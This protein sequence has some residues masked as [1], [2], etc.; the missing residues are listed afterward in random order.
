MVQKGKERNPRNWGS[1]PGTPE[2]RASIA[3]SRLEDITRLVSEIIWETDE[4]ELLTYVSPRAVQIIEMLPEQM[5]GKKLSDLGTFLSAD[6]E[7]MEPNWSK[8]FR[9]HLFKIK[10]GKGKERALLVSGLP[11]F[12]KETWQLRGVYGTAVD[13]TENL[14]T[15]KERDFQKFAMD[16]HAIVSIVDVEGNITYAND[17]FC[18][19]SGY[20][21]D[22]LI[23][24]NHRLVNSG[25]HPPAF[26]ADLW[27]T[28]TNGQVWRGHIRNLKKD[29]SYYWVDATI[30]PSLN[31]KGKPFQYIAIRTDITRLKET[32]RTLEKSESRYRQ[33]AEVSSDWVWEMDENLRFTHLSEGYQRLTGIDPSYSLGK[34]RD[35]LT[36]E[37][38][39]AKPQWQEHL[40]D[41]KEMREFRNF[42]YVYVDPAGEKRHF[43]ISGSPVHDE[44]DNFLGYRGTSSD[45]SDREEAKL[46][47]ELAKDEADKAN[48]AKSEFLSSM[49]HELRTPMNAILGFG[50]MLDFN[51]QEPLTK[52]QKSNVE[53]ILKGGKHLLDLINDVLDLTKIEAGK[54]ELSIEDIPIDAV[55]NDS[56]T[57]VRD[58][59][60]S[61]DIKISVPDADMVI[62]SVRADFTRLKQVVLNL[63]SNA[64]KY[65]R[66]G[67]AVTV[68]YKKTPEGQVRVSITDTGEGI[69]E[70]MQSELF[71]AFSRL[72]AERSEI[73]G[74]GIGLVVCQDLIELMDGKIGF[75]SEEGKGSTF[76]F[77]LSVAT[78]QTGDAH[79]GKAIDAAQSVGKLESIEGTMLYVEDNP[80]NLKLME[81]IVSHIDGLSMLSAHTAE[82]GIEIARNKQPDIIILDINLSG[83]NGFE[84][85][86]KLQK[87]NETKGIPVL[88]LS[89]AATK[90]NIEK[91]L[92]AGFLRYLTKPMNVIE[93]T[94][95]IRN[96]LET[97]R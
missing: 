41:M 72:G 56:L 17:K 88:A 66:D 1:F 42:Q 37:S 7:K 43:R 75:E 22:E 49:S 5:V 40:L 68:H 11:H 50:Q 19:I 36:L 23:G 8:P 92:K 81:M 64:I 84:A 87:C 38:E 55:I 65:N 39:L 45:V 97:G 47:L 54:I 95:A 29:G 20:S 12:D 58:M 48:K 10:D 15:E 13:I 26:Y 60:V 83:M 2:E 34:T 30:V 53:Q 32:E 86:K 21:R 89:A 96:V 91:G 9:N 35:Q 77:E 51:P 85:L 25:L 16:E 71:Q 24:Q 28:I 74:T 79:V 6:N 52:A 76:W 46:A 59:A 78:D 67:G 63:M 61:R 27:R 73:E 31:E 18:A 3:L 94:D 90:N 4:Q 57:L 14:E 44:N 62:L 33:V 93:V 70:N 82:L 80:S 69:P